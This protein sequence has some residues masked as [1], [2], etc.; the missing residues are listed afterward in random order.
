MKRC[1]RARWQI[2][3]KFRLVVS[4]W[5]ISF[6]DLFLFWLPDSLRFFHSKL[7][8]SNFNDCCSVRPN[9]LNSKWNS[10]I[11]F[12]SFSLPFLISLRTGFS[13]RSSISIS[14]R[15]TVKC[16]ILWRLRWHWQ[17]WISLVSQERVS[18][19]DRFPLHNIKTE[20]S[21]PRSRVVTVSNLYLFYFFF[22]FQLIMRVRIEI[23]SP[24]F[25]CFCF[26]FS[27]SNHI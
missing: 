19:L 17:R 12:S 22:D 26:L 10:L 13:T 20:Q 4:L 25:L 27:F 18:T 23:V 11:S 21:T 5:V 14:I 15:D 3:L 9:S 16:K 2:P 6:R 24:F 7:T 8:P 1:N